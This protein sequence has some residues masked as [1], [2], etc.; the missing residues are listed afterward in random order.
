VTVPHHLATWLRVYASPT[1]LDRWRER[2]IVG[3][4]LLIGFAYGLTW[5]APLSLMLLVLLWDHQHSIMQQYGFSRIYD[6]KAGTGAPSTPRFDLYLQWILFVN[7]LIVSPLWSLTFLR[8]FH[9]W[10]L[11]PSTETVLLIQ[12]LSWTVALS[13][14]IA[15]LGH[16]AWCIHRGYPLNPLKYGFLFA[17]YFLWYYASFTTTY[18]LIFAIAHR[19][20]HGLQYIVMV[21]YYNRNQVE[22]GGVD[23]RLLTRL[24]TP[25]HL[26]LFVLLCVGY[27][28][29][30]ELLTNSWDRGVSFGEDLDLFAYSLISSFALVHYY[31]DSFIWKVRRPDVQN[32]L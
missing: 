19:L 4:I 9:E 1:E 26:K 5:L 14:G 18:L 2:L 12:R 7:M 25:G 11:I 3:P 10:G 24:G 17:S 16:V 13:Y 22:R 15:F 32:A 23:S 8:I 27:A 28:I 29:A 6:F 30:F 20:M 21:Y 31:F